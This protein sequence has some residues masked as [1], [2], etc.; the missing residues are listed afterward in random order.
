MLTLIA[1]KAGITMGEI[2]GTDTSVHTGNFTQ[3]YTLLS[4]KDPEKGPKYAATAAWWHWTWDVGIVAGCN[5]LHTADYFMSL[6]KLGFLSADGVCHSFDERANGYGR[7]EGFGVLIIKSVEDAIHNGDTIRA[8]IRATR[9]NQNGRTNL[10]QPSKE[11][12]AQLI[13]ETYAAHGLDTRLTRYF[14]AHGT[15]TAVGDPL[16]AM[17]IG[18]AFGRVRDAGDPVIM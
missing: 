17:A 3:D 14:E 9:T 15:G 12:Q 18:N 4:A 2:W 1:V 7:G 5:I 11:M 8:V 13:Q 6:S 16:E 10:A